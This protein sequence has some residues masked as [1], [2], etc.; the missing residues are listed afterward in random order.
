MLQG[1]ISTQ[2]I[3]AI[4][5]LALL[6]FLS[7]VV[8][9]KLMRKITGTM[10]PEEIAELRER[11]ALVLDVRTKD[12]FFY[13]K[14]TGSLNIAWDEL[15]DRL[16]ELDPARPIIVCCASGVRAGKAIEILKAAGF[17]MVYNGGSWM[18]VK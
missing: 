17:T 4:L 16:Q 3:I 6:I 9:P 14:V 8:I 12:E 1:F 18:N 5:V 7:M 13:G 11:D 15:P 2:G 10:S